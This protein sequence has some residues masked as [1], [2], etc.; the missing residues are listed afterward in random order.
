MKKKIQI[1]NPTGIQNERELWHGS[2]KAT[3]A[4]ICQK[5]FDRSFA[6]RNGKED[7]LN[8]IIISLTDPIQRSP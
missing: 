7:S 4:L 3:I 8:Y 2:D 5:G 6:G 1:R